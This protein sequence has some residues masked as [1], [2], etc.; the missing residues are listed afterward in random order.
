MKYKTILITG[1]LGFVGSNLAQKIKSHYPDARVIVF[2]NMYRK[3][4]ELNITRLKKIGI[5]FK[6]G[7][8]RKREDFVFGGKIDLIIE[9]AAEPSVMA[10]VGESPLYAVD[11]NLNGAIN[12]LEL[13]RANSS[14][15]IFLST[16]RVYPVQELVEIKLTEAPTR[17]EIASRQKLRG[18]SSFGVSE[19]FPLGN[20][21]TLYGATKLAA[22]FMIKEYAE[23][24]HIPSVINRCGVITG[25]W[26][27]G[28][29]DQGVF[30]LWVARHIYKNRKLSYIG[31]GGT[32]K[33]VRDFIH[34]DDLFDVIKFDMN[35]LAKW[36]GEIFNIGGGR[37]HSLSLLELTELCQSLSGVKL[38][39]ESIKENRVGDIPLYITDSRKFQKVSGWKP[40]IGSR[41]AVKSLFDWMNENKELL[42][43]TLGQ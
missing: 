8:V 37:K 23:N 10:G 24:Y 29:V 30:S 13:A 38:E 11:T 20:V 9:C 7:D 21:R 34:I 28:K 40:R 31:F 2:D 25:P 1:G 19:D 3:G 33:Q 18:I 27:F 16:S 5:E 6:K 22:E 26:Q 32:G 12:C 42:R 15:L 17:F 14:S 39:V 36:R 43:S 41:E 4:S 35:N